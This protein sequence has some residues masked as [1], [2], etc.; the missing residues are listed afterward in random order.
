MQKCREFQVNQIQ[1]QQSS[2]VFLL[3][4]FHHTLAE[5]QVYFIKISISVYFMI[6]KISTRTLNI[7][8]VDSR[9][10]SGRQ[11]ASGSAKSEN[12]NHETVKTKLLSGFL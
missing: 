4:T 6:L 2:F 8:L 5:F 9:C 7:T 3:F 1:L 12:L 10:S 11:S